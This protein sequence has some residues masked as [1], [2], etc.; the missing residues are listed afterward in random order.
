MHSLPKIGVLPVND[1]VGGFY[2][3]TRA[4]CICFTYIGDRYIRG[5]GEETHTTRTHTSVVYSISNS[6]MSLSSSVGAQ[7]TLA[8]LWCTSK[9]SDLSAVLNCDASINWVNVTHD[10]SN[11]YSEIL[12]CT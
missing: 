10:A 3:D 4:P 1:Q 6:L 2:S 9:M 12:C 8:G 7:Y 5:E 11:K